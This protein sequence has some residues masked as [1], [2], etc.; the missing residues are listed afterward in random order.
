MEKWNITVDPMGIETLIKKYYRQLCV[1]KFYNLEE[2]D[3]CLE[4]H[5]C[6]N[7]HKKKQVI[8][9]RLC[10][11]KKLNQQLITSP[12]SK[13]QAQMI[14]LVNSAEHLRKKL[15]LF[16]AV[17]SRI[18]KQKEACQLMSLALLP[19]QNQRHYRKKTTTTTRLQTSTSDEHRCRNSQ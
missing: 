13:Y 6:Q 11:L 19:Y 14:S 3:Q 15:Y 2:V 9:I 18:Q 7:V 10:Q 5:V 1:H 17:F 4:G 16:S 12:N 8:G